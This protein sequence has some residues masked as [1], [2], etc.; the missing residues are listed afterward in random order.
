MTGVELDMQGRL[1]GFYAVTPQVESEAAA[2]PAPDWGPLFA[3]A[4]LDPARYKP[5][6]PRW[7]P[8]FH[9]DTRAAWVSADPSRPDLPSRI[10][11]A[12]YRGRPVYFQLIGDW[13]RP[14]RMV[15]FQFSAGQKA[16]V[17]VGV[18]LL[19]ATIGG[20][21]R[22]ARENMRLGRGD[23]RG[24][25]RVAGLTGVLT[26]L[27]WGLT[28]HHVASMLDELVLAVHGISLTLLVACSLWVLY[29]ALEPYVRRQ[30]P[31]TLVS[32]TRLLSGRYGDPLVARDLLVGGA[33]GCAFSL[34][35][36]FAW[37][38]L[39]PLTGASHHPRPTADDDGLMGGRLVAATLV[40]TLVVAIANGLGL[41]L[42]RVP[43]RRVLRYEIAVA[44]AFALVVSLENALALGGPLWLMLPFVM[45]VDGLPIYLIVRFG[46]LPSM[47]ALFTTSMLLSLPA[48]PA[49]DHWSANAMLIGLA[50]SAATLGYGYVRSQGGALTAAARS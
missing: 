33:I 50:V 48:G 20:A 15:P 41:A 39:L 16:A 10:E 44:L 26:L 11:A 36:P 40:L 21:L 35:L 19:L 9:T 22:L 38:Y 17:R 6:A 34:I 5:A 30:W 29:M 42:L 27:Y 7:T 37:V 2:A 28:A 4:R 25:S 3:E 14:E 46:L 18:V 47:V 31:E 13:T 1:I 24:A 49:L 45:A 12:A 32:W 23:R 43:L 8:P